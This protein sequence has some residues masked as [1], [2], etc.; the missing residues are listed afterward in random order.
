[1][2]E[3]LP[4]KDS[5][6]AKF[7]AMADKIV[8]PR[9]RRVFLEMPV[10]QFREVFEYAVKELGFDQLGTITGQDEK[11]MLAAQY[12]LARRDG[13]VFSVKQRAPREK[14]VI[15]SVTDFFPGGA[16]YERELV[17]LFGFVVE[18]L[19][20][21]KRYPMPDDFPTDQHPLRKDWK[22]AK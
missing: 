11:E 13:T 17:D 5:L 8:A 15:R 21:G 2:A 20:P 19:P 4:V 12:H 7:P 18:G 22:P 6:A 9:E 16:N 10:E 1:M 14:P 3:L